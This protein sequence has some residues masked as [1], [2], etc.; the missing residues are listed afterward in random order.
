MPK[1]LC[2]RFTMPSL[3]KEEYND[4]NEVIVDDAP[5]NET[6]LRKPDMTSLLLWVAVNGS[7]SPLHYDLSEG[8]LVQVSGCKNITLFPPTCY[9]ELK[10]YP[11]DH[12]H[13]RQSTIKDISTVDVAGLSG[14]RATVYKG[15]FLYIP[16]GWWHQVE[17]Y[18]EC[19]SVS[20][21]WNPY[22]ESIRKLVLML[23]KTQGLPKRAKDTILA[24]IMDTMPETLQTIYRQRFQI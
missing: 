21:R 20:L 13:D 4:P 3:L 7:C 6:R 11:I 1:A 24:P 19:V 16:F 18:S 10:P 8:V 17:S 12:P 2:S 9:N 23:Q 15:E 5:G 14:V 22:E